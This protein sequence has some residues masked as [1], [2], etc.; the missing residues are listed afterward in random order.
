VRSDI[1]LT[2]ARVYA[3]IVIPVCPEYLSAMN[4]IRKKVVDSVSLVSPEY[5]GDTLLFLCF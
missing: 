5:S 3:E 2:Q 1:Y 4:G